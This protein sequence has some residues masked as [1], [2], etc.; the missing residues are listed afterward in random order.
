MSLTI[1][2]RLGVYEVVASLGAGGMGEVYRATDTRLGRQVALKV[3]PAPVAQDA[4]R[5]ARFDREARTLALLNHPNIAQIY[6]LEDS[7]GVKALVME[8]VEGPT[9]ANRLAQ[10]AV[11][12]EEAL[13][14][15]RQLVEALE[16]AHEQ[17][18]I[19]RDLKPANIKVRADGTVKVLDFGLA[20]AMETGGAAAAG[21]GLIGL[22]QSP[23]ITSPAMT[24]LGVILGTA[25]YMAPEQASGKPV[26]KRADIWAFGVV[27]WEM[28]TG[29]R[30][31]EGETIS[32]VLAA[33]L[34]REPDLSAVPPRVRPLLSRCLEKEARKRLRDIGD[35]MSL[36]AVAGESAPGA[37]GHA[38]TASSR[39]WVAAGG[40]AAAGLLAAALVT[41]A[42][43]RT[44]GD[45][46]GE[47]PAV[48]FQIERA[49]DVYNRTASGF[50]VSPDGGR[51]AY[52]KADEGGGTTLVVQAL[53]TGE[54][55]EISSLTSAVPQR[56]SFFWSPDSRQLV[57]GS[58]S[59][60]QMFD[61]ASGSARALCE[62]RYTGGAWSRDGTILLGAF[63]TGP[64]SEGISRVS[65][66]SSG[67][68]PAT[69][70]DASRRERD[71]FPVFLPDGR[72]FLF[73]RSSTDGVATHVG[74]LDGGP[75]TRVADGSQRV[76]IPGTA[77]RGAYLLGIDATGLVALP[78]DPEA[79]RVTG[80]SRI[81]VAGAAAVSASE[82]GVL[83]TS[84]EGDR[85]RTIPTWFDRKGTARGT[86][87]EAASI[88]AIA[89][90][91]DGRML[92]V[93]ENQPGARA[94]SQVWL[95]DLASGA[96]TR[97]TFNRGSTPV[98]SPDGRRLAYTSA[99]NG[100]NL[101]LQKAADG[102]GDE[103]PLFAYDFHAWT[104][105]WSRDGRWI[106]FSSPPRQNSVGNDLWAIRMDGGGGKP[107]PYLNTTALE[108]QAQFSP[109]GRF[110]AYGSDQ[111]GDWEIY[112][113]PFPNAS[114]G[115]WMVSRGG[116]VEPRWSRDG[117]ELLYFSGQTLMAAQ[118][119]LE[120]TFSSGTPTAL[121]EAPIVTGYTAD[122]HRWQLAPDG[123]RVL[124]LA[125]AGKGQGTPLDVIV[126]CK[127]TAGCR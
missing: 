126:N 94:G 38:P 97:L 79:I 46:Q 76:F 31:F 36:V 6:G 16:A 62:C 123:Q 41:L 1:G 113:Q 43:T 14:I 21:P 104:N 51:I 13:A 82:N 45:P 12:I 61:L 47:Q 22:S 119:R 44:A 7:D 90:S 110:I 20:K 63:G 78:F 52:Y 40:W 30:M 69:T 83:A 9:L 87:G 11:P 106:V 2:G 25:A 48:R 49:D 10:G 108:Q 73:T 57:V 77:G 28:L 100:V 15:A 91:S 99:R 124:V 114:D 115:K 84:A 4:E 92:A 72:R 64:G 32:H 18:I 33:V 70:V 112:V 42:W 54:V 8:L 93:S 127:M 116:G 98:W 58:G 107:V 68:K 120:P 19:H 39:R 101:P 29:R 125:T 74:S 86:I 27:L 95:Q 103:R 89:L 109:D 122:S 71:T 81:I 80:A 60:A 53:A 117:K 56:D 96:R 55:R 118:V 59:G 3:L 5:L 102:R 67:R 17:G 50:A 111:S 88:D 23:T 66:T 37:A 26:D 105:D 65:S 121:F 35:A 85:P 34:T 24:Q 75:V